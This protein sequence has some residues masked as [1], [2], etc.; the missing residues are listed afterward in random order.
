M[1]RR[2]PRSTLFPYTPLFRSRPGADRRER[3][4]RGCHRGGPRQRGARRR[5]GEYR[6]PPRRPLVARAAAGPGIPGD[7]PAVRSANRRA[8]RAPGPLRAAGTG[9]AEQVSRV[10]RRHPRGARGARPG[11]RPAARAGLE[12]EQR[13]RQDPLV[14]GVA[15]DFR[16]TPILLSRK[17]YGSAVASSRLAV[18]TAPWAERVST[19]ISTGSGPRCFSCRVAANLKECAGT[20]RSSWSAVVTS[21]A[22]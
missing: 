22:G 6:L 13:R 4:R 16:V 21:V 1:I 2:P 18:L 5:G 20:T 8:R 10:D 12:L 14:Q 17:E 3:P 11:H 7:Q 9:G 15:E 19:R